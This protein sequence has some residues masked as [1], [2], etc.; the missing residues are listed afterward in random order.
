[1]GG[2]P[3][4]NAGGCAGNAATHPG[5]LRVTVTRGAATTQR[6]TLPRSVTF[7]MDSDSSRRPATSRCQ[8]RSSGT[9]WGQVALCTRVNA[10]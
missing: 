3:S 7:A 6:T 8:A 4:R 2:Q 5:A 9:K 1:M 10:I